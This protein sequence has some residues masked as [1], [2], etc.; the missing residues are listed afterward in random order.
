MRGIVPGLASAAPVAQQL[1]AVYQEDDFLQRFAVAFDEALAP[2]FA[3]LDGLDA[4]VDPALAPPDFL[5]W[6]AEWVGIEVD[7]SWSDER[8]REI[9]AGAAALHRRRGTLAGVAAAVR[10]SIGG[11]VEVTDTGGS[12]WSAAT[13][14]D[15]PGTARSHLT[16]RVVVPDAGA[17]DRRRAEAVVSGVKPAHVPHTLEIVEASHADLS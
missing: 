16:V 7:E 6:L 13:G 10:L 1:P 9:I 2:I 12:V 5:L 17:V 15:L 8:R 4:Y 3:T 11:Q 14:G